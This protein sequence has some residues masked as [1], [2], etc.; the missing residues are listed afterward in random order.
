MRY[1]KIENNGELDIR[2]VALMGGSTKTNDRYKI[3]KFGTGLKYTLAFLFRNN[4]SFK[5]FS[6]ESLIDVSIEQETIKDETFDIICINNNRTSITTKMGLD[7]SAWMILRELWCNALDE[8]EPVKEQL[9]DNDSEDKLVGTKDKTTFYIQINAEIEKV[10]ENWGDYF[11]QNEQPMFEDEDY[12][13]Y[14]ND[15]RL[16]LY[17][18]G[19]LI[20]QHPEVDS[21]FKYDIKN[22]DINELREFKGTV[23]LSVLNA[24]ANP[25]KETVS[26]F[27]ANV[28]EKHYEGTEMDYEWYTSFCDIWKETIGDSK[29]G[30]YSSSSE[31]QSENKAAEN[32]S[33]VIKLPKKIYK[34]LTKQ[35]EGIGAVAVSDHNHEFFQVKDNFMSKRIEDILCKLIDSSYEY[36]TNIKFITGV[37]EEKVYAGTNKKENSVLISNTC[38]NMDEEKLTAIIVEKIETLKVGRD[39]LKDHFLSLFI[40]KLYE[41]KSVL[42]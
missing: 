24:L 23:S 19:V 41:S 11:I 6:G 34:A 26:Y 38:S 29:V 1:L 7:W 14:Q 21:L 30:Y 4:L 17:K 33:E 18:Q 13:I 15:G 20:Y 22:A 5:I 25:N 37:F 28:K 16:K 32:I 10:L 36:D 39:F 8:G 27:L 2:L 9:W 35:F 12:G 3:G 42:A 40:K 31:R